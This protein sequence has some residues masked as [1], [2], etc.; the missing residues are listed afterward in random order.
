MWTKLQ[1]SRQ[2]FDAIYRSPSA[3]QAQYKLGQREQDIKLNEL[4][5]NISSKVMVMHLL[6]RVFLSGLGEI[7]ILKRLINIFRSRTK[8]DAMNEYPLSA[9]EQRLTQVQPPAVS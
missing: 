8:T 9:Q 6:C 5:I 7:K 2:K 3:L 4:G 1:F